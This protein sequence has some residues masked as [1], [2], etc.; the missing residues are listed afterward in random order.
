MWG[1]GRAR[2]AANLLGTIGE[3]GLKAGDE[4]LV[5]LGE[6]RGAGGRLCG[7]RRRRLV[8]GGGGGGHGCAGN[9]GGSGRA[10]CRILSEP[11]LH[12]TFWLRR[13]G[14]ERVLETP[15]GATTIIITKSSRSAQQG[16]ENKSVCVWSRPPSHTLPLRQPSLASSPSPCIGVPMAMCAAPSARR[17]SGRDGGHTWGRQVCV[18]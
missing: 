7:G 8:R 5:L 4:G 11:I 3:R 13:P 15:A 18:L 14:S 9:E 17:L 2:G 1:A 6:R 16:R 10:L 12:H